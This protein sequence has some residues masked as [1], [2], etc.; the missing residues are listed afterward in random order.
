MSLGSWRSNTKAPR[1]Y[2]SQEAF[3]VSFCRSITR[4]GL[5]LSHQVNHTTMS[6]LTSENMS[7]NRSIANTPF[8]SR[9]RDERLFNYI[10]KAKKDNGGQ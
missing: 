4:Y 10:I 2:Q 3:F 8:L 5:R 6:E 9:Q 7:L 1:E